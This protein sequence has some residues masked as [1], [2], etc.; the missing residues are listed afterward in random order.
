MWLEIT[1]WHNLFP[2][3][4]K[5]FLRNSLIGKAILLASLLAIFYLSSTENGIQQMRVEED[6][7]RCLVCVQLVLY[8]TLDIWHTKKNPFSTCYK[9]QIYVRLIV[10]Y[11]C[12]HRSHDKASNHLKSFAYF[13][14]IIYSKLNSKIHLAWTF[15]GLVSYDLCL[16]MHITISLT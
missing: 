14:L 12:K 8:W 7:Y 9:R 6:Q 3:K 15:W 10:M 11:I 4:E 5:H 16:Y 1:G 13:I 2:T